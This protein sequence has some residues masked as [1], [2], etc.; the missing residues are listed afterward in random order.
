MTQTTASAVPR[1]SRRGFLASASLTAGAFTFG[2]NL[3]P[4]SALAQA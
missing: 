2:F 3:A 1:L 4:Q